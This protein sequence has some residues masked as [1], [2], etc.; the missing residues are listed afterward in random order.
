MLSRYAQIQQNLILF[1][2]EKKQR[3][4]NPLYKL[5]LE[6]YKFKKKVKQWILR[7]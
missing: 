7:K 1:E 4:A 6:I 5:R 2:K 3:L